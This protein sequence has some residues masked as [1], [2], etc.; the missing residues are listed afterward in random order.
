MDKFYKKTTDIKRIIQRDINY[1]DCMMVNGALLNTYEDQFISPDEKVYVFGAFM[2]PG[3]KTFAISIPKKEK[4][5]LNLKTK[6]YFV[7][8]IIVPNREEDIPVFEKPC[9]QST[10]ERNFDKPSSEFREWH[11]D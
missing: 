5:S 10:Y 9:K 6:Q 3:K 2:R 1:Q 7:H 8:N 11:A 4:K